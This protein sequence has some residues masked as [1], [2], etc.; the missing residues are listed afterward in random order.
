MR[1]EGLVALLVL[2]ALAGCVDAETPDPGS[3]GNDERTIWEIGL[4]DSFAT[5]TVATHDDA[6][7]R[8]SELRAPG[9]PI[10]APFDADMD[11]IMESHEIGAA[12]MAVMVNG[13][14][15]YEQGY[16][17]LDRDKTMPTPPDAMFRLASVT[18]PMTAAVVQMMVAEGHFRLDDT[19]LCNPE[20][21]RAQCIL[22]IPIH[23]A[24]PVADERVWDITVQDVIDHRTGWN[25]ESCSPDYEGQAIEI[26]DQLGIPS[27]PA[28]WRNVQWLMGEPMHFDPGAD[29]GEVDGYCNLAYRILGLVAEASTGASL[30]ALDEAYLFRPLELIGDIEPGRSLPEDRNP[31]EPY[32]A[33]DDDPAPNVYDRNETV[34][35]ADGGFNLEGF[36]GSGGLIATAAAVATVYSFYDNDGAPWR[37][38]VEEG[39]QLHGGALP[40]TF[41]FA[42]RYVT[43]DG[44]HVEVVML[45]NKKTGPEI[46]DGD[47]DYFIDFLFVQS[48]LLRDHAL[49]DTGLPV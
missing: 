9:H 27:P 12:S 3:V 13:K 35:Q 7:E 47:N 44:D 38:R 32:Y 5:P 24:R 34:C 15:R 4:A 11:A 21:P 30:A 2:S 40:G 20:A 39:S 14:L 49:R 25:R 22:K 36:L 43:D 42:R 31:R 37:E 33:C 1:P 46:L 8:R 10:Y 45:F 29:P 6:G 48:D 26:A 17:H 19:I 18:K 41:T 16:G 28:P 23:P